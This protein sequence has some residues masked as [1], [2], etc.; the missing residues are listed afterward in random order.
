MLLLFFLDPKR[1]CRKIIGA[2]FV[3]IV[4]GGSRRSNARE[5]RVA[6]E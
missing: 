2:C 5:T 1:P 6:E 4:L 3:L